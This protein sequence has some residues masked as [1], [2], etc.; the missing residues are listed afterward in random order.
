MVPQGRW[1]RLAA[2]AAREGDPLS[3]DLLL[4][5][6]L[7]DGLAGNGHPFWQ[8]YAGARACRWVNR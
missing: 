2:G 6:A 4:A 5:L 7:L 1:P 8:E 3:W